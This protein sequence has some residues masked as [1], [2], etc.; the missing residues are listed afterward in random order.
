MLIGIVSVLYTNSGG[1]GS[2]YK[3]KGFQFITPV[4]HIY[5]FT[6]V[7]QQGLLEN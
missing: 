7:T 1:L 6:S 3:R 5:V 4:I 2:F